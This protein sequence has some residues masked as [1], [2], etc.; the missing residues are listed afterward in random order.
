VEGAA[1]NR[2]N[3]LHNFII[4]APVGARVPIAH[5]S[6]FFAKGEGKAFFAKRDFGLA[7]DLRDEPKRFTV[8]GG[9]E[10]KKKRFLRNE[11][12]RGWWFCASNP[13][14]MDATV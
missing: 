1:G 14:R 11:V 12:R 7:V 3:V 5:D 9:L 8:R 2:Q 4:A 10:A 13:I 6:R